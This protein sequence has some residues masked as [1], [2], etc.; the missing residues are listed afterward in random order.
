MIQDDPINS[1]NKVTTQ[2]NSVH[3]TNDGY[4]P[5]SLGCEGD[6]SLTEIAVKTSEKTV[7]DPYIYLKYVMLIGLCKKSN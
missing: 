2:N 6:I 3:L 1:V 7:K 5:L 4:F